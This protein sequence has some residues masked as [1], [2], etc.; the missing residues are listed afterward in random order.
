VELHIQA[1]IPFVQSP[2]R[3]EQLCPF[4]IFN[5][6]G[7]FILTVKQISGGQNVSKHSEIQMI[8]CIT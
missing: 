5:L 3:Q 6:L 2:G 7:I 1:Y 4:D 8:F